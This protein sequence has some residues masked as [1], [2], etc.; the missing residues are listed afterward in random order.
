ME[1]GKEKTQTTHITPSVPCTLVHLYTFPWNIPLSNRN[2]YVFDFL[3][4][5]IYRTNIFYRMKQIIFMMRND[6]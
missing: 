4:E 1:K 2:A 6:L 3:H 5:I